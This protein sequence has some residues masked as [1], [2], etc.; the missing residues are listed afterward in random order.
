RHRFT[1]NIE[2]PVDWRVLTQGA[3]AGG[4]R[5]R[6]FVADNP[7]QGI[8]LVAGP[9]H[10]YQRT[11]TGARA[12]VMLLDDDES[13]ADKYLDAALHDIRGYSDAIGPYPYDAFTLVENRRQTGWGMPAFT[14]LGSRIIRLPF[15]VHT[16]FP[17]EIL[18]NWWGNGVFVDRRGA[19][20]SE[21]LTTYLSDHLSR[22]RRGVGYEYRRDAL[23]SWQDFASRDEDFPLS[24]FV[25][26]H[27]RATQAVGYGKGMFFFHMLRREVGDESFMSALR[28]FYQRHRYRFAGYDDIRQAFETAC[29][30]ELGWFFDQWLERAGAPRLQL[31]NVRAGRDEVVFSLRQFG[32]P[33]RLGVPV[34]VTDVDGNS[35]ETTLR[36]DRVLQDY[37]IELEKS[38]ARIDIDPGFDL[39]RQLMPGER[40]ATFSRVFGAKSVGVVPLGDAFADAAANLAS[41][42]ASWHVVDDDPAASRRVE[43][44]LLIGDDR[45]AARQWLSVSPGK[46][47]RFEDGALIIEDARWVDRP[48]RVVTLVDSAAHGNGV[49]MWVGATRGRDVDGLIARLSHYGR[50]SYAVLDTGGGAAASG[51]WNSRDNAFGR[52]FVPGVVMAPGEENPLF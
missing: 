18:H 11:A 30:C 42:H 26:R 34:R 35:F 28:T 29:N 21:G 22:E 12:G 16:S 14:L 5:V 52:V 37:T 7:Q 51:Q 31:E 43:T 9:W 32:M 25:G 1:V 40:P 3:P 41:R 38:P 27:D 45:K 44:V 8:Y 19:N 15:I 13:L 23:I 33:W 20:W 46:P 49:V 2:A 4:E 36:A 6:R 24:E 17:H 48:G 47:Y 39:F 50:S 10:G